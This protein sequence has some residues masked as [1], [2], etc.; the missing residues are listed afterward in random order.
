MGDSEIKEAASTIDLSTGVSAYLRGVGYPVDKFKQELDSAV[1]Y[2]K[3][4]AKQPVRVGR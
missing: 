3:S 1:K 4:Q 2:M